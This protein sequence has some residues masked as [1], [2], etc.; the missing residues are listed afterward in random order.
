MSRRVFICRWSAGSLWWT[1]VCLVRSRN[2]SV[3]GK[4]FLPP[5]LAAER[6]HL[7]C[8]LGSWRDPTASQ[9]AVSKDFWCFLFER[10]FSFTTER[11]PSALRCRRRRVPPLPL[12]LVRERLRLVYTRYRAILTVT[13]AL[14]PPLPSS[15]TA[16]AAAA[17]RSSSGRT[18]LGAGKHQMGLEEF[19]ASSTIVWRESRP[20]SRSQGWR[21]AD[22]LPSPG[23]GPRL[24]R[25]NTCGLF[26]RFRIGVGNKELG[27]GEGGGRCECKDGFRRGVHTC[28]T[29]WASWRSVS[30]VAKISLPGLGHHLTAQ[31]TR[32]RPRLIFKVCPPHSSPLLHLTVSPSHW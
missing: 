1:G 6:A 3:R 26:T 18:F 17:S 10:L 11:L 27:T 30:V 15:F 28:A 24:L 2:K 31:L 8:L 9:P 29:T 7:F 20:R 16:A 12:F 25:W 13:G 21:Q 19:P 22:P 4:V 23:H 14:P 5:P 32:A